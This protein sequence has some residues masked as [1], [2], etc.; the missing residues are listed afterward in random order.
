MSRSGLRF[1]HLLQPFL[2]IWEPRLFCAAKEQ[3]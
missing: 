2:S 3:A 1:S